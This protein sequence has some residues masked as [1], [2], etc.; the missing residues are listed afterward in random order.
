MSE[1]KIIFGRLGKNP[2]LKY[3]RKQE[4]ICYLSVAENTKESDK[5]HWHK[6][7]VWG[8]QAE[9]CSVFLKKGLPIFVRGQNH[10]REFTTEAGEKKQLIELKA[11][12]VGFTFS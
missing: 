11:D 12:L 8:K 3:T 9:Q 6:V 7:I 4:P 10:S 5:P 2:E 1:Q